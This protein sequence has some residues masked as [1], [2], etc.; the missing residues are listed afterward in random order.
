MQ[1]K[2]INILLLFLL[3][4]FFINAQEIEVSSDLAKDIISKIELKDKRTL[5]FIEQNI[6]ILTNNEY[7][8]LL[9]YYYFNDRAFNKS[10]SLFLKLERSDNL[11]NTLFEKRYYYTGRCYIQLQEPD[12]AIYYYRKQL[13]FDERNNI[14]DN[15][16][17]NYFQLAFSFNKI[18]KRDSALLYFEK[19]SSLFL[20]QNDSMGIAKTYLSLGS[21][22]RDFNRTTC[23]NHYIKALKIY[24]ELN[25]ERHIAITNQNIGTV[26]IDIFQYKLA[27]KH[28][29]ESLVYFEKTNNIRYQIICLNNIGYAY[30]NLKNYN[31]SLS[32]LSKS[33]N[34]NDNFLFEKTHSYLNIGYCYL[35]LNNYKSAELNYIKA[36]N[37]ARDNKF[38]YLL[39]EIFSGLTIVYAHRGNIKEFDKYFEEYN[40]Y[41]LKENNRHNKEALARFEKSFELN[42]LKVELQLAQKNKRIQ[43]QEI[44]IVHSKLLKH[45]TVI[46][47]S[48]L[49]II[50]LG[51][52]LLTL[53]K[54]NINSKKLSQERKEHNL[55][56][57]EQNIKLEDTVKTRTQELRIAKEKAEESDKLKSSFLANISHEIRTPLN[58]IIGF[59]DL[60]SSDNFDNEDL[61]SY[62]SIIRTNG[63][64]LLNMINDII[65]IAKIEANSFPIN[66]TKINLP[67]LYENI[68]NSN[69]EKSKYFNKEE[70]INFVSKFEHKN[71]LIKTDL[72]KILIVFD[73]LINNAFLFTESGSIEIGSTLIGKTV[74]FHV[75]NSAQS[76]SEPRI[77]E[78][79]ENF[80][81]FSSDNSQD[82]KG[83]GVGLYIANTILLMLNSKLEI[84]SKINTETIFSFRINLVTE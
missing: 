34:L 41:T 5:P 10:K 2:K 14:S 8:Y 21:F 4:S 15:E 33:L 83:I 81:I 22:Y 48:T 58:S 63:F 82:Y 69:I 13:N 12:S 66:Q 43:E 76:I 57:E 17:D 46:L 29:E 44:K 80:R 40:T 31:K 50:L 60:L 62:G 45:N 25:K 1:I 27:L 77:K 3:F 54:S 24:Q 84:D 52:L 19:A 72:S 51:S 38:D 39:P 30:L 64:K 75:K 55:L 18:E 42:E 79:L 36:Q 6:S 61:K 7:N 73:K 49:L 47:L 74:I 70:S 11:K 68:I 59:S 35:G 65:E 78:I 26:L 53:Y 32:N 16:A 71:L 28:L 23:I 20:A 56:I 9:A 67:D 37:L